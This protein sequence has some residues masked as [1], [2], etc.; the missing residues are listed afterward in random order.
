MTDEGRTFNLTEDLCLA[1][2]V[3]DSDALLSLFSSCITHLAVYP[4]SLP[5]EVIGGD[6]EL[7]N[8]VPHRK[9]NV[10]YGVMK[11]ATAGKW[12]RTVESW[13]IVP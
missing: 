9:S 2:P 5:E 3:R 8:V 1:R 10:F 7:W 12:H 13:V 11:L 4:K 6:V